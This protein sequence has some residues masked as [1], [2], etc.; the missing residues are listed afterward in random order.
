MNNTT[1]ES[2]KEIKDSKKREK[3]AY[4]RGYRCTR[5]GVLLNPKKEQIGAVRSDG[6]VHFAI[7]IEGIGVSIAAHRL[8]AY[9]K[10]DDRI[11]LD[12]LEVRHLNDDKLDFAWGNIV[13]GTRSQNMMDRSPKERKKCANIASSYT[14]KYDYKEI[15]E[16]YEACRSRKETMKHFGITSSGTLHY[17]LKQCKKP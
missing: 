6:Y 17:I 14:K 3:I 7:T 13:L 10:Y 8:Q 15:N 5:E 1:M 11:Y 12:N 9:Q 2:F 16:F 4:D